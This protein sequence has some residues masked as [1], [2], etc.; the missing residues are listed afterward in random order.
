MARHRSAAAKR[1]RKKSFRSAIV[2][3]VVLAIFGTVGF[4]WYSSNANFRKLD[5]ITL[6]PV[7]PDS[8]TVLLVDVTDPMTVPQRQDFRNQFNQLRRSIKRYGRLTI[9]RVNSTSSELLLPVIT[10]CNP[11]QGKDVSEETGNPKKI[12]KMWDEGFDAPLDAAFA[13]IVQAAPADQSPIL[14][15]IQS[16]ALTELNKNRTAS[17][18]SELVIVSDLLQ[19]TAKID[20]YKRLPDPAAL[21]K[22]PSFNQVRTDLSGVRIQLWM[23]QRGDSVTT[24]PRALIE[25]WE[26]LL[27]A[28][29]AVVDRAYNVSG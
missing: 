28:E 10:R 20:F 29:G 3:V 14:E 15:S 23:L 18:P 9:V 27:G 25:L 22:T 5:E 1:D 21:I 19:H 12:Q 13:S 7:N 6:C 24:Q 8:T 4:A 11:G 26:S 16:V 2:I 17:K